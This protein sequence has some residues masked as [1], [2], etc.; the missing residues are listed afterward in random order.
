MTIP[1]PKPNLS[2]KDTSEIKCP[3]GNNIFLPAVM[4]RKVSALLTGSPKDALVPIEV[5]LCGKCGATLQELFPNELKEEKP[6][7]D[8][9]SLFAS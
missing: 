8:V 1:Q 3:C 9:G 4:F 2:L 5:F 6:K 7:I